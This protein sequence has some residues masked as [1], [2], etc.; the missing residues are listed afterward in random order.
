MCIR[1]SRPTTLLAPGR[2][3]SVHLQTRKG[4]LTLPGDVRPQIPLPGRVWSGHSSLQAQEN[5][6]FLIPFKVLVPLS[7]LSPF[8][9]CGWF[10]SR[11][12]PCQRKWDYACKT[13]TFL[14]CP[15]HPL[16]VKTAISRTNTIKQQREYLIFIQK[17][18]K[19]NISFIT[20]NDFR[21]LCPFF[22]N[23]NI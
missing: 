16:L 22:Y 5:S 14:L 17:L 11:T 23:A 18:L 7:R 9:L 15:L 1:D 19:I 4:F 3:S 13:D 12:I 20:S 6:G 21:R 10:L 8:L 2:P